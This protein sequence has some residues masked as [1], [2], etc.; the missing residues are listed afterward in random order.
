MLCEE[1]CELRE[2]IIKL[3]VL[4]PESVTP[5][6]M[7][8]SQTRKLCLTNR[9]LRKTLSKIP[10]IVKKYQSPRSVYDKDIKI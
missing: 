8:E 7:I 6:D 5:Q 1:N 10:V 4:F 9:E 2:I 3:L